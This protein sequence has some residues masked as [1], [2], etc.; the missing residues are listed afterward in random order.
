MNSQ[1]INQTVNVQNMAVGVQGSSNQ[2]NNT[3]EKQ[4]GSFNYPKYMINSLLHPIQN[5]KNESEKLNKAKVPVIL[6]LI[7]VIIMLISN[8]I[9]TVLS[10]VIV[11]EYA[12]S[13][14]YVNTWEWDRLE[15]IEWL[16]FLGKNFLI[17][18]GI[19]LVIAVV[20]YIFSLIFKK[21]LSFIKSLAISATAVIPAV[22][23][24][25]ILSP[26][27]G[28]LWDVLSIIV[29]VVSLVYSVIILYELMNDNLNFESDT[30]V[31]FNLICFG[32]ILV[33]GYLV[34]MNLMVPSEIKDLE[35]IFDLF[36]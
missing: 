11:K 30:K 5:F 31:Y 14:K 33:I 21:N 4:Y 17:Y 9:Q 15:G 32:I 6:S 26:I 19:I 27:F 12:G 7:L 18:V 28:K 1:S 36:S 23:G 3:Q 10:T 8:V 13:G 25:M 24:V 35:G 2:P 22:L 20:F 16:E 34:Y 29:I